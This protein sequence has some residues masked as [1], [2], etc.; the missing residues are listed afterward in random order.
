M[1]N[2]VIILLF[3]YLLASLTACSIAP[4]SANNNSEDSAEIINDSS[5]DIIHANQL[6]RQGKKLEAASAYYQASH[7]QASP[8]R[9][10]L[11]LQAAEI[12]TYVKD[13]SLARHYLSKVNPAGLSNDNRARRA[14]VL[15]LIAILDNNYQAALNILPAQRGNISAGL[16]NKIHRVRQRASSQATGAG[17]NSGTTNSAVL[18]QNV[19][20]VAVLLPLSG[21]LGTLG[22]VILK[23]INSSKQTQA[24]DVQIKTYDVASA[25]ILTQYKR[26]VDEGANVIIGPLDKRKLS[27]LA[28]QRPQLVRPV[29]SLNH[30]NAGQGAAPAALYQFGLAPEDEARQV[31]GFAVSRGQRRAAMLYPDSQWGRRLADAFKRMYASQGGQIIAE[32]AYPNTS[33]SYKASVKQVLESGANNFDMIFLAASPTQARMI[34]PMI[35]HL[36]GENI[37]VYATSHIYSGQP[38]A[39]K[40]IDLDGIVYTEIPYIIEG[41]QLDAITPSMGKYP[42]LFA[43]GADA[44]LIA[45]NLNAMVRGG[46]SLQGKTGNIH[47]GGNRFLQRKL[48][49]ATFVNGLTTSYGE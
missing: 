22:N 10:R 4:P 37:P 47:I 35:Q 3:S 48:A 11:V 16:W 19:N 39:G 28:K 38:D 30:L 6:L 33:S 20:Q 5:A 42:R 9:E 2:T 17:T 31:A 21:K 46:K 34:R 15:A 41:S 40:N 25:D 8:Q 43:M 32:S 29:I 14:Y 27:V 44:L 26:A 12:A 13:K 1:K 18:P 7:K 36:H 23:G 49:W 45:K 24:P